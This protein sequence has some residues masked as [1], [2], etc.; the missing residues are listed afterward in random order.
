MTR[1]R[2]EHKLPSWQTHNHHFFE[3]GCHDH[4]VLDVTVES[5]S[6]CEQDKDSQGTKLIRGER[7]KQQTIPI[8]S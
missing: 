8:K 2:G 4:G 7:E 1:D 3:F 5:A 6:Q